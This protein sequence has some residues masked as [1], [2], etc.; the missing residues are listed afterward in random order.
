MEGEIWVMVP[1]R[2]SGRTGI[3]GHIDFITP[4]NIPEVFFR[5]IGLQV[6]CIIVD[7]RD[8]LGIGGHPVFRP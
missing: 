8:H 5:K 2:V 4:L 6:E 1:R 7:Y 3:T